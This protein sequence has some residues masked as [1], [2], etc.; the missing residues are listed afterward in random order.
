MNSNKESSLIPRHS[1]RSVTEDSVVKD[2]LRNIKIFH[3]VVNEDNKHIS[4]METILEAGK[5]KTREESSPSISAGAATRQ[6]KNL[7]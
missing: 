5:A 1:T 7:I 4:N 6:Q 3:E 2:L